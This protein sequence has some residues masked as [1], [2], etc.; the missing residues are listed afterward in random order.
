MSISYPLV[1]PFGIPLAEAMPERTPCSLPRVW[2]LHLRAPVAKPLCKAVAPLILELRQTAL[3]VIIE[4]VVAVRIPFRLVD[5]NA[6]LAFHCPRHPMAG[7]EGAR[8][9]IRR[10][11]VPRVIVFIV[12]VRHRQRVEVVLEH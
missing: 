10:P 1:P 5:E 2:H 4:L 3:P 12:G 6:I 8:G 7:R 9:P 11:E